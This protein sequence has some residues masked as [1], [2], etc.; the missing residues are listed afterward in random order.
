MKK[1]LKSWIMTVSVIG[2]VVFNTPVDFPSNKDLC[3]LFYSIDSL[4]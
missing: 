4:L 1:L 2:L 3:N